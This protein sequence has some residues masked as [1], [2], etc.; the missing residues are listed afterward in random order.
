MDTTHIP[1]PDNGQHTEEVIKFI[2]A[3][4]ECLI[5]VHTSDKI[6]DERAR[7]DDPLRWLQHVPLG[8]GIV[9][10]KRVKTEL[11]SA[12]YSG[13]VVLEY[14]LGTKQHLAEGADLW[15]SL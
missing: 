12:G 14:S 7:D 9:D 1:T 5:H 4:P 11:A 13:R 2:N 10:W 6:R 8:H 15:S 3:I